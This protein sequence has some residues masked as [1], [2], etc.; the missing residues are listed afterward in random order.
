MAD[1]AP[2]SAPFRPTTAQLVELAHRSTADRP[3]P[4]LVY[5]RLD[6][7]TEAVEL[8]MGPLPPDHHPADALVGFRAPDGWDGVGIVGTGKL[9]DLDGGGPSG[10]GRFTVLV[11]RDEPGATLL[12]RDGGEVQLLEGDPEGWLTDVL[13]RVLD[14]PTPPPEGSPALLI[15]TWWLDSLVQVVVDRPHRRPAWRWMAQVHP[16]CPPGTV[17]SP[18]ELA[19]RTTADA[20]AHPWSH[21][22]RLAAQAPMPAASVDLPDG[23]VIAGDRW[24][25]DG[26]LAR[27]MLRRTLPPDVLVAELLGHLTPQLAER[28][29]DALAEV[30]LEALAAA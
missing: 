28:V 10:R 2:P 24:F 17:P 5:V 6:D 18:A 30:D 20:L 16:L 3:G 4:S 13:R 9:H 15:D 11:R 14:R 19:A 25:D 8:G 23:E 22:R 27:W 7:E 26:T 29:G 1:A 21:L 12:E